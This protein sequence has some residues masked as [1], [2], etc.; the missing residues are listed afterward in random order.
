MFKYFSA[1]RKESL[2][3]VRDLAGLIMLFVMPMIMVTILAMV[4]EKGWGAIS[5]EPSIPVLFVD[6]DHDT[7]AAKVMEGLKSSNIFK[8]YTVED[9]KPVTREVASEEVARGKYNVAVIISS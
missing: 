7:L 4:Q 2:I 6:E 5:S 9:G 1:C 8:I 3:L